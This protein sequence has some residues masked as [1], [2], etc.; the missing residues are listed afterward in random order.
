M[1]VARSRLKWYVTMSVEAAD[2]EADVEATYMASPL[3][4]ESRAREGYVP[5]SKPVR[6]WR[7]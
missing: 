5:D 4:S 6:R 1:A 3:V 7:D 2:V